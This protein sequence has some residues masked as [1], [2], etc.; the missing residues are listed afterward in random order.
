MTMQ[1]VNKAIEELVIVHGMQLDRHAQNVIVT[2]DLCNRITQI[3]LA[4]RVNIER[5]MNLFCHNVEREYKY[6]CHHYFLN[7]ERNFIT[8]ISFSS[9]KAIWKY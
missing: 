6:D 2:K 8:F 5:A 3:F 4:N 1:A 7:H 9:S